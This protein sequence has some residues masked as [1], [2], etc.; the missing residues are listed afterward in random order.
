APMR[1]RSFIVGAAALLLGCSGCAHTG[2]QVTTRSAI[3]PTAAQVAA[4][5]RAGVE[6]SEL[7]TL[8]NTPLYKMKP[9]EVGRYV[10]FLHEAEP[11]LR[12]RVATIARKNIG[13]PYELYLLGEFPYETIDDQPLFSL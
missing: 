8:M 10:A 4:A 12:A 11:D 3:Q 13:Q 9:A 6:A 7:G 5:M 2:A 1:T